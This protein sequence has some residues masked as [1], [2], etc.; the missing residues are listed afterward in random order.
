M[1][2]GPSGSGK[3]TAWRVLLRAL[4]RLEGVEGVAHII[5]PKVS[6]GNGVALARVVLSLT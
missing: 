2:V 4:E 5:D 3:S 1:M 6:C